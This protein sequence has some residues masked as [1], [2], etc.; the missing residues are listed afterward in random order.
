MLGNGIVKNIHDIIFIDRDRFDRSRSR[1]VAN[2]I[3]VLNSKLLDEKRPFLLIGV[4]RWGTLDPWL[5]IPVTW[6]QISGARAIIETDFKDFDVEPSQ[7][8]HFFHNLNSFMVGYF[9]VRSKDKK[10]YLDWQWLQEREPIMELQ[11]TKLLRFKKPI[12][13]KMDGKKGRGVIL[14]PGRE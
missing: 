12:V 13:I 11:Y 6:D 9:T 4:G 10:S 3:S 8:S 14:K 1:I 2:E 5:G 7:G